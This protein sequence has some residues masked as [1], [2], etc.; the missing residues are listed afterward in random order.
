MDEVSAVYVLDAH[1]NLVCQ[2]YDRLQLE[3][4][5]TKVEEVLQT[6][7]QQ[8]HHHDIVVALGAEPL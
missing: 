6:W 1:E 7:T 3:P 4:A 5:S 2:K 8:L